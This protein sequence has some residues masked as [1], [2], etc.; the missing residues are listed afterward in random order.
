VSAVTVVVADDHP[1]VRDGL[2]ALLST[3]PDVEL[4]GQAASGREAVRAAVTLR[5]DILIMDLRMPDLDGTSATIEIARAAPSVAVLVL[6]MAD[7]EESVFSAM[8]A[9]ARGYLVKG[10]TQEEI[11]SAV[12]TVA[13]GGVV[14]G[15]AVARQVIRHFTAPDRSV[16]P[17]PDLTGRERQ[18]LDL[19]AAGL[20]NAVIARR[21]GISAKTVGNRVSAIFAKLQVATRPEAIVRAREAGL[22]RGPTPPGP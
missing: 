11:R 2:R 15:P 8:R 12:A 19:M 14:F 7:D 9:G 1:I 5:P 3:L 17:F 18:V 16:A 4:V 21:L 22:G 20:P 10:A 6:T 13:A